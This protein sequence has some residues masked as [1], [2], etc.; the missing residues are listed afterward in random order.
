MFATFLFSF[1][2]TSST[3]HITKQQSPCRFY[4]RPSWCCQM[5]TSLCA[6]VLLMM[7]MYLLFCEVM[8]NNCNTVHGKIMHFWLAENKVILIKHE[9]KVITQV[10]ITNSAHTLSKFHQSWRSWGWG[11]APFFEPQTVFCC[12]LTYCNLLWDCPESNKRF[13]HILGVHGFLSLTLR[14]KT[15]VNYVH[16]PHPSPPG[17]NFVHLFISPAYVCSVNK[18]TT[19]LQSLMFKVG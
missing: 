4:W 5:L 17:E 13:R 18:A 11:Y 9:Y 19:F 15:E 1:S 12:L 8:F 14:L 6:D 16:V 7:P 3:L 10:Q 2:G